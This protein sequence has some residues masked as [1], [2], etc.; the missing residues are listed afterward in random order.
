MALN[1]VGTAIVKCPA[2]PLSDAENIQVQ[3]GFLECF[4]DNCSL[5][6]TSEYTV[7]V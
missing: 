4:V 2:Q 7:G 3:L 1:H 5:N 6:I